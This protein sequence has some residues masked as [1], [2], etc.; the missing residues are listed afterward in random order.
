[1]SE[2][3][4]MEIRAPS[5]GCVELWSYGGSG[6]RGKKKVNLRSNEAKKWG[7]FETGRIK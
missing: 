3:V 1:M 4:R 2:D 6:G 5:I 7:P